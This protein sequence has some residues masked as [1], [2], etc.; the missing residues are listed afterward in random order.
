MARLQS[1]P[2]ES[3][4]E[5]RPTPF[6]R[7]DI[8]NLDDLVI[9]R[10]VFEPGWHWLEHVQP[11]ART[12]LCQYHHVG[13]CV[14]G[15]LMNRLED[16]TSIEIGPGQVFEIPPGHDGWVVGDEPFV[17]YDVAGVR[18]FARVDTNTQRVL[19]A[20]LFTDIVDSTALAASL[21]AA[22]WRELVG[23]H[24]ERIQF[25]LDRFRGRLVKTTGDGVLALFDGSER[26]V[27]A[28]A[29][30]CIEAKRLGITIRAG[31]HTGEVE[32]TAGDVRGLAVHIAARVMAEAGPSEVLISATTWEL[33]ADSGLAFDDAGIHELKGVTGARQLYRLAEPPAA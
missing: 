20:V 11:I 10:M 25:E 26:A 22:R 9:G 30:I 5:V 21:G 3:P 28:A 7:V 13:V 6:G 4:D 1:K 14:S 32:L 19:G 33:V 18:S 16:G 8:Y 2:L 23:I 24:N 12:S 31:V 17:A 15:R 27:R 29:A